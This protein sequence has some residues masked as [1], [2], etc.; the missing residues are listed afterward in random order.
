MDF[1]GLEK[2]SLVDF[3][4]HMSCTLFT[5]GCNFKCP[6]CH[7]SGLV[8]SP[9]E[10]MPIPFSE[11]LEFLKQRKGLLDAV[12]V[13]G[14]EPTLMP[15]LYEKI[16]TIKELG[17]LVKLDTNGTHPDVVKALVK[18]NLI[19]YVAMDIK[20]SEDTYPFI[21]NSI[22]DMDAVKET[23]AFLISNKVDYEFRTTLVKEFHTLE[24][25]EKMAK[26]VEGAK[27]M[28]LQLFV[29]NAHC[30]ENGLHE[31]DLPTAKQYVEVLK[32]HVQDVALR[33]YILGY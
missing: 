18:D 23:I 13:T 11:I 2:L 21:T 33:G 29:D 27:R 19:D 4:H 7:N 12:V 28:R 25:I 5:A 6:F 3:D 30:I 16:K 17:Y 8:V 10:N 9:K 31:V 24:D 1:V 22:V 14:G 26:L 15:D 32:N 20:A